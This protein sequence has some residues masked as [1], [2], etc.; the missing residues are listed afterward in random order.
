MKKLIFYSVI[1]SLVG[2]PLFPESGVA[3]EILIR[4]PPPAVRKNFGLTSFYQQWIDVEGF[5]VVASENVSPYAMKEAVWLIRQAIGHRPD[6]LRAMAQGRIRFSVMAHNEMTTQ[7][8][9]H[10]DL[11]PSFYWDRRTRG[12]GATLARPSVSCGEE[13]LLNY[14]GD[15]YRTENILIHEFAH[16]VHQMGLNAIDK[17]FNDRLRMTFKAATDK[18]LWNGTYASTNKEEYWAEGVQSWFNTN[19]ENDAEHNN[20]NTRIELK[21]YD[22]ELATLLTQVFGDTDWRY[23]RPAMRAHQEHLLGFDQQE[24]PKFI[25]PPELQACYQQLFDPEGNGGEKWVN[26]DPKDPSRL[27]LLRSPG[28]ETKSRR[29]CLINR[30]AEATYYL[31]KSNG[32]E[33]Y[34]GRLAPFQGFNLNLTYI[35]HVWLIKDK[36]GDNLALFQADEKPGRVYIGP[37]AL[38]RLAGHDQQGAAGSQLT[39]PFVVSVLDQSGFASPGIPVDFSLSQVEGHYRFTTL[40]PMPKGKPPLR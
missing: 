40:P 12:L 23:T 19:R 30:G 7:I 38:T 14:P 3:E 1:L 11:R 6:V 15:P 21:D 24:L 28:K 27:S 20:V 8:P 39:E 13:N 2:L 29:S 9:E 17:S 26:L 35:G 10:S 18:G 33:R 32:T 4:E 22:P 37:K 25:W 16:A 36:K 5:P 31:V 34:S